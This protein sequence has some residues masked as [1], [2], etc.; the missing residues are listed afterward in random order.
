[1]EDMLEVGIPPSRCLAARGVLDRAC[2]ALIEGQDLDVSF[3]QRRL[4]DE[5][6]YLTMVGGKTAALIACATELGALLA[7]DDGALVGHYRRF[8]RHLGF[9]FQMTDDILGIWG[10]PAVTG[11]PAASDIVR[12]KKTLPVLFALG[13]SPVLRDIYDNHDI[14]EGGLAAVLD[15]LDK[16][17][18]RKYTE[19]LADQY[20]KRGLADLASTSLQNGARDQLEAM[21]GFLTLRS[22]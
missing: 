14:D 8:G 16:V 9:A 10:D 13:K 20:K 1:M 11:K 5:E 17:G 18:A 22:Y 12:K 21:A 4:V 19:S 3:E 2:L 7:S 6:D 15:I